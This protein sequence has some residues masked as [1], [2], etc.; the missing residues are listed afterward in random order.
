MS[1][2]VISR[3]IFGRLQQATASTPNV[4]AELCRD[5]IAEARNTISQLQEALARGDAPQVRERAHYLKGSSMMI[6]AKDLTQ[7]CANLERMG[8]D[9]DLSAAAP[10]LKRTG[11]A[12]K[13]VEAELSQELGPL[14]LPSEG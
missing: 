9:S 1:E 4:L 2:S 7:C 5:Y 14:A 10:E 3:E 13:A 11:A 12:L 8:R 6:G